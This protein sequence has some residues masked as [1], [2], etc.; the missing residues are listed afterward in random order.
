[1]TKLNY[2]LM[3]K[4]SFLESF[5]HIFCSHLTRNRPK[6]YTAKRHIIALK[7]MSCTIYISKPVHR[8]HGG[9][10]SI[11]TQCFERW[12]L[13][14]CLQ[15]FSFFVVV[16]FLQ[17]EEVKQQCSHYMHTKFQPKYL[18]WFKKKIIYFNRVDYNLMAL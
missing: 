14:V 5:S 18:I 8:H 6:S 16:V 10:K 17:T 13:F 4:V 12:F 7:E 3:Y 2:E 1:M 15:M 11:Q 9:K